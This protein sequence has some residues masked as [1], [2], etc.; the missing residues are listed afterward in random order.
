MIKALFLDVDGV[1][2]DGAII[3][4]ENGVE[5]K[6]FDVKDG[7]GIKMAQSEGIEIII[8]SGRKSKVTNL[9]CEELGIEKIYTGIKD[10]VECYDSI[11]KELGISDE[12]TAYMGDDLNDMALLKK[13]GFSG[14]PADAFGY[15]KDNVDYVSHKDS[16]K[17]AVRDFIEKI[18]E[19]NGKWEKVLKSYF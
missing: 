3:Y 1:L 13:V 16:G 6:N 19:R 7:F 4:D 9:R 18:L 2:S 17:G 8:I 15:M 5:T 14:T 10:K 11:I 12:N